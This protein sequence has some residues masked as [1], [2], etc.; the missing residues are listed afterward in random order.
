MAQ[1]NQEPHPFITY[2]EGLSENRAALA[3]LRRGLGKP[4][5]STPETFPY[6]VPFLPKPIKPWME[7]T[8][9]LIA[10]LFALHPVSAQSGNM[11]KHFAQTQDPAEREQAV[12]RRFSTLL[13]A[14]PDDLPFYLRQAVSYLKSK[15]VPVNW[16]QLIRD[17]YNWDHPDRFVQHSWANAFWGYTAEE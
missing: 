13:A 9:Y 4:A 7:E 8:C 2:L 3:A 1:N 14:H 12:E 11:G 15:D 10:S 16:H 17:I 5:G 6:V